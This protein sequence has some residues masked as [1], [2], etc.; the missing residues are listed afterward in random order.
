MAGDGWDQVRAVGADAGTMSRPE[1]VRLEEN[2]GNN[3]V[4]ASLERV[5][6]NH[7]GE[8]HLVVL[9][10][11]PD[12]D[13]IASA[14]A[15][16]LISEAFDIE[17][18]I[19]YM[20]NVS[21]QQNIALARVLDLNLMLFDADEIDLDDYD[22]AVFVDNQGT[23]VEPIVE[24]LDAAN[25]PIIAIIDHHERQDRLLP[26]FEAIRKAGATATIYVGYL[27]DG[28]LDLDTARREHAIMATGLM[29]GIL[30]DTGGFV[31]AGADDF[32]AA[33]FLARFRDA[34]LLEQ[35]MSQARSK[36]AMDVIQRALGNRVVVE[37]FSIAGIGF[38]RAKDRDAIPQAADFLL[39]EENVHTAIVYGIV[40]TEDQAETLIGSLRTA[41]F[42]LDPD[43]F[44]KD[45]FGKSAQGQYFGGGKP[46]A[47][48]FSIPLGFLS[49][50]HSERYQGLKWQIYDAQIKYK[51]FAKIGIEQEPLE[52]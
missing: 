28:I 11:Y 26:E 46:A 42:T 8:K 23:T 1:R 9:H 2:E 35:I 7:R 32:R 34:E 47:G 33:A 14:Y 24:G 36:Q 37:S 18:D 13:A 6:D 40:R 5:L 41:K 48:G 52:L 39:T 27:I 10:N 12:P 22:G 15:H 31:R 29:H 19:V 38:V 17:V 4:D 51:I 25:V 49:G 3:V 21:H 30:S 44:I 50:D 20:G 45:V 43:A 16:R